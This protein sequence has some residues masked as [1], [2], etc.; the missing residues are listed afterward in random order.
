ME[1]LASAKDIISTERLATWSRIGTTLDTASVSDALKIANLDFTV[2]K[3]SIAS[4]SGIIDETHAMAV[5]NGKSLGI[6]SKKYELVQNG[7]AFNFV[8]CISDQIRFKKA[9]ITH[10]GM[11]Y[12]IGKLPEYSILGDTF[13]PYV[14]FRNSFNGKYQLSAAITPLRLVCENQFNFAFKEADNTILIRHS[15]KITDRMAEASHVLKGVAAYMSTLGKTAE[16]F[17]GITLTSGNI[18]RIVE[19]LFP[20][21]NSDREGSV[22]AVRQK[23]EDFCQMLD[24]DDNAN[25]KYTAWGIINAYTDYLT[26]RR[27]TKERFDD[28]HFMK[29]TFNPMNNI[30]DTISNVLA[31]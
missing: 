5:A 6:V 28:S 15:S 16:H 4:S 3:E 18:N 23:K 24:A 21:T 30:V 7:D 29:I 31:A 20:I 27:S 2:S 17:A 19:S 11:V 9:G 8:D 13:E 1:T 10:D 26:H 14:I 22:A 25:H 12:L